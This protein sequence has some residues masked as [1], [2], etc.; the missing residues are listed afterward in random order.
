MG[1]ATSP[2]RTGHGML[3][4]PSSSHLWRL[5]L[6]PP[7]RKG[8]AHSLSKV[9]GFITRQVLIG[10]AETFKMARACG[11]IVR[12]VILGLYLYFFIC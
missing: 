10:G 12:P 7:G 5:A 9:L 6:A 3:F 11:T 1:L 2:M 8:C 4:R